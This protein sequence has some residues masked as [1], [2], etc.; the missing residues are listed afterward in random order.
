MSPPTPSLPE[1]TATDDGA[2]FAVWVVPGASR[3][4]INGTHDGA[5]RVRVASPPEGG[6]A[7][8]ALIRLLEQRLV[9]P[10]ELLSGSRS[11]AKRVLARGATVA[12]VAGHLGSSVT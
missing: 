8:R 3:T 7:N 5:L 10:V 11:R 9:T 6:R 4:E 2:V 12:E 1:I